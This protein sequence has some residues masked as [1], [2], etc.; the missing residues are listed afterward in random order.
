V[1]LRPSRAQQVLPGN[2]LSAVFD[3]TA[4]D[5]KCLRR[6]RD[7]LVAVAELLAGEIKAKVTEYEASIRVRRRTPGGNRFLTPV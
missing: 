5:R 3:Q 1:G 7:D 2:D 4:Q 6:E